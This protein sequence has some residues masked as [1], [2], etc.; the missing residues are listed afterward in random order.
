MPRCPAVHMLCFCW[1]GPLRTNLS[2]PS[3][4]EIIV[5]SAYIKHLCVQFLIKS[6]DSK[7]I[8]L[9]STY[10]SIKLS[11]WLFA[12]GW[13]EALSQKATRWVEL[14]VSSGRQEKRMANML[15]V[16]VTWTVRFR[17]ILH[18]DKTFSVRKDGVYGA[19]TNQ[20]EVL[21]TPEGPDLPTSLAEGGEE[22]R[23]DLGRGKT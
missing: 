16:R 22:R 2:V 11:F 19:G 21:W 23:I 10:K 20:Q 15:V 5:T 8:Y 18:H 6:P 3:V 9:I 7:F 12:H 13:W 14:A 1:L 4:L 17:M